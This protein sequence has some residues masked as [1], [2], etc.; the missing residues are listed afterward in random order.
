MNACHREEKAAVKKV[1]DPF[2][3][4]DS[5]QVDTVLAGLTL[6][7]KIGQL[8]IWQPK[9]SEIDSKNNLFKAVSMSSVGGLILKNLPLESYVQTAE[10]C[11]K[12]APLPLLFGTTE[13]VSLHNQFEGLVRFPLPATM[14]AIDSVGIREDLFKHYLDQCNTLGINF[15]FAPTLKTDALS[16]IRYDYQTF[17]NDMFALLERGHWTLSRM[18]RDRLLAF[19]D[20]FSSFIFEENDTIRDKALHLFTSSCNSGLQGLVIASDIFQTDTVQNS[21]PDFLHTYLSKYL[22]FR[23]LTIGHLSGNPSLDEKIL[24]STDVSISNDA[25][26][27]FQVIWKII[28]K[29]K[30]PLIELDKRVKRVLLAKAWVNGGRLPGTALKKKAHETTFRLVN[31]NNEDRGDS[32]ASLPAIKGVDKKSDLICAYFE[33]PAWSLYIGSLF[34]KSIVLA[35][36]P[37]SLLPFKDIYRTDFRII[38]F[39]RRAFNEFKNSFSKYDGF[40]SKTIKPDASGAIKL[41]EPD[42]TGSATNLIF[43]L[44]SV[45]L[46]P[47][48]HRSFIAALKELSYKHPAVVLN[49]GNPKNLRFFD[50][51]IVAVQVFERN[52]FT[53]DYT[54]QMLFGGAAALGRLPVTLGEHF[55]FGASIKTPVVR[56]GYSIPE[57]TG[58]AARRLVG[59]DAIAE[60]AIDKGVFP[61]CQVVVAKNGQIIYTKAFGSHTY[62][63]RRDVNRS[64]LYDIASITKVAATTL[65]VMKLAEEN[66]LK[67]KDKIGDYL[68][69]QASNS[70]EDVKIIELLIHQSGL[71]AQMPIARFYSWRNV[72]QKGCN[73]YFCKNKKDQYNVQVADG[74][75]LRNDYP[76]SIWQRV[77]RLRVSNRK[78]FRYSDVNFFLLQKVVE[79]I[80]GKTLEQY[81]TDNF[82]Q[83]LGLHKITFHPLDYF[84]KHEIVPTEKDRTW[85]KTLVHGF[86]HDPAAALVGGVGGNAGVF[87]N[88]EDLAALFQMLLRG[89]NYGGSKY[90][91]PKTIKEFTSG[92]HGNHRGLGFDKPTSGRQYPSYSRHAS[93]ETYGH[94]G[95]TG[96]CVWVDPEAELVYIFLSNRVHPSSRNGK[97]FTEAVRSRIHEVVY[98]AFDTYR[99]QLPNLQENEMI[100]DEE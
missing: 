31:F 46:H 39:T 78:R 86:V 22:E 37:D 42:G 56:L 76:D 6:E 73:D 53:E 33:D 66:K 44:D 21:P 32:L 74:L 45:D 3:G 79:K 88:A 64:D 84:S 97:I 30:L 26:Q 14:S 99:V 95:F 91:D 35:S 18:R 90:F 83:P 8:I 61:G 59:I 65:A 72:P 9:L 52:D 40:K 75:Y 51:N 85:R 55:T 92:K 38:E 87:A 71:Q 89:G 17:E 68:S 11:K 23:G 15:S 54:A 34:E 7:E 94:T 81:V 13:K 62:G 69:L 100:E 29:G 4:V 28:K 98:D 43:I 16:E 60:T 12:L 19:G 47:G 58:I 80:S 24:L 25:E 82:Y 41:D 20:S 10:S 1:I 5:S 49:F 57:K 77:F 70:L 96:T 93:L 63:E 36:N 27:T 48:K 2:A 67:L 50:S